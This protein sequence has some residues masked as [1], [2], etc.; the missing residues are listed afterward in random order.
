MTRQVLCK[1][2][3]V[4]IGPRSS[5][6]FMDLSREP[7]RS[8]AKA[9]LAFAGYG[10]ERDSYETR[11][12][13][14]KWHVLIFSIAG[15]GWLKTG[16]TDFRLCCGD[17]W[18]AP[19][20]VPHHYG[21]SSESWTIAWL[22]VRT[23]NTLGVNP[24]EPRVIQSQV[25]QQANHAIR[26]VVDESDRSLDDSNEMIAAHA[27]IL[28]LLCTRAAR[29]CGGA[30]PD[31][32]R[33]ML[34]K[35]FDAVRATPGATW[36]VSTLLKAAGL[37]VTGDRLRQLCQQHFGVSPMR[38]VTEIRMQQA[39]ELLMATDY[40]V[41]TIAAMMGYGNEAAFSTAFRRETG[42]SPRAYRQQRPLA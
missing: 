22:C 38:Y 25:A 17:V 30:A 18:A 28:G 3:S 36:S 4:T 35:A 39:R 1:R 12:H 33:V 23:D 31:H 5:E 10:V 20:G 37:P 24:V 34:E 7:L 14:P 42:L 21:L 9:G 13:A 11:R 15:E 27:R 40:C 26:Q 29:L 19:A 2:E 6:R 16:G 8:L 32:R 41:Y